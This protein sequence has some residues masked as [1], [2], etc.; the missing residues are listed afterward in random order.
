MLLQFDATA[1][2]S[3]PHLPVNNANWA[4]CHKMRQT[5]D[6]WWFDAALK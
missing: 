6:L 1:F 4:F 5:I 3:K 2:A